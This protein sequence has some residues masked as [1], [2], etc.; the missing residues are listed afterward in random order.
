MAYPEIA[1]CV[2]I[3]RFVGLWG[4][5]LLTLKDGNKVELRSL[6]KYVWAADPVQGPCLA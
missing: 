2:T 1:S 3:G 5:I 4:D 6:E